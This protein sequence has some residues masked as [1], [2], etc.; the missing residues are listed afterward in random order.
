MSMD[1]AILSRVKAKL[2]SLRVSAESEQAERKRE[3]Y[4]KIPRIADI[5]AEL[6][7]TAALIMRAAAAEGEDPFPK[8]AALQRKNAE[9]QVERAELLRKA[10]YPADVLEVHYHC[11]CCGDTGYLDGGDPC[12][13]L[14]NMYAKEQIAELEQELPVKRASFETF[15]ET[16][17]SKISDDGQTS[18]RDNVLAVRNVCRMLATEPHREQ[19]IFLFGDAGTGK[20]FLAT[21]TAVEASK[22]GKSVIAR[23]M[24]EIVSLYE[25]E[26]F[27]YDDDTRDAAQSEIDRLMSCDLLIIDNLGSEFRSA[28]GTSTLLGILT[29][30]MRRELPIL[31]C[32]TVSINAIS[33]HYLESRYSEQVE[34]RLLNRESFFNAPLYGENLWQV[35]KPFSY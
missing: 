24:S 23:N 8:F 35:E 16:L 1:S 5:D 17:Y 21:A 6:G 26:K 31:I 19:G 30:R 34:S 14:L 18:P 9:H 20:T 3:V 27:T 15:D 13:C 4:A 29:T 2:F 33:D 7:S 32:S 12:H 25:R 10:G 28:F 11:P 22:H